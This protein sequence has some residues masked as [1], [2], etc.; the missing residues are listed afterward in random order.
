MVSW[1]SE[2]AV[3]D[4]PRSIFYQTLIAG[5]GQGFFLLGLM[6]FLAFLAPS[7]SSRLSLRKN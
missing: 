7:A 6:T 2:L 1:L 3:S 5:G 4:S